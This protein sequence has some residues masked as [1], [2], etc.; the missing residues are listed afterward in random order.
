MVAG[1]A[2]CQYLLLLAAIKAVR[3]WL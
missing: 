1:I 3:G 2:A